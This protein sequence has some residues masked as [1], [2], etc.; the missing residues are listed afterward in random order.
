MVP[1]VLGAMLAPPGPG[2]E[3]GDGKERPLWQRLAWM[4]GIWLASV[5][6]LG[7]VALIIRFWLGV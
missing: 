3:P 4:A 2:G 6:V 5:T 7:V 1:L